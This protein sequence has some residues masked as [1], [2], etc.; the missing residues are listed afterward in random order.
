MESNVMKNEFSHEEGLKT[1]YAMIE[2][3]KSR[4]GKNYYYY[5]LWGYLVVAA[6]L[7]E[8]LLITAVG[9]FY[10]YLVWPVFMGL[11]LLIHI[12]FTYRQKA[13]RKSSTYIRSFMSFLWWGWAISYLIL[14]LFVNF[15]QTYTIIFP[16][17]LAMYGM[18]IFVSGGVIKFRP[19]II[20]GIIAWAAAIVTYFI[21]YTVQLPVMAVVVVI[22]YL[23]PGYILK[24]LSKNENSL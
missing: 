24:R 16:I 8:Y 9:Y 20:G 4:I 12:I 23:V 15:E 19:L 14:I 22:A 6:C 1:I 5:L 10:H 13:I 2:S 18:V 11:G 21:P 3:A 17:T 7:S